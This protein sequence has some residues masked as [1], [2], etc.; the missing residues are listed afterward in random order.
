[1][2]QT[3]DFGKTSIAH[4]VRRVIFIVAEKITCKAGLHPTARCGGGGPAAYAI[5]AICGQFVRRHV[6]PAQRLT[7]YGPPPQSCSRPSM[8]IC[9]YVYTSGVS[10]RTP[11]LKCPV[12]FCIL[13][14]CQSDVYQT[15]IC[16]TSAMRNCEN[17]IN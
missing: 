8:A 2:V 4:L 12:F 7:Y 17:L 1:M 9:V 10:L 3:T 16:E 6:L 15:I 14:V 13:Y 11:D 5:I